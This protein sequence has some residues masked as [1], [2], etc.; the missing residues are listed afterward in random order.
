MNAPRIFVVE[1]WETRATTEQ[2]TEKIFEI[3][4]RWKPRQF[5]C[6][7][8]AMQELYGE[9]VQLDARRRNIKLPLVPVY[10]PSKIEKTYRIRT[11]L[12]PVIR[13]G[14]LFLHEDMIG[15]RTKLAS[16]PMNISAVDGIDAL[17]NAV[18]LVPKRAVPQQ[19]RQEVE[20]LAA[21]LRAS[22]LAPQLIEARI[23]EEVE[24]GL[25][26]DFVRGAG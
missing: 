2:L 9:M 3:N 13:A 7:A 4:K 6:E 1:W 22:G 21:Y 14:R 8:N 15:E 5:G 26:Q 19:K 17:E 12:Q 25:V 23:R 24:K 20:A 10:Q 18:R 11:G 16:F